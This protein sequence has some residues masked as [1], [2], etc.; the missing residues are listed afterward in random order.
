MFRPHCGHPQAN[1][2]RLSAFNVR[3]TWDPTLYNCN[4]YNNHYCTN[5][6]SGTLHTCLDCRA[7]CIHAGMVTFHLS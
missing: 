2:Y 6:S 5:S 4:V 3:T 1:V 7:L